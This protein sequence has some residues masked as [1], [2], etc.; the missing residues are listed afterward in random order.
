MRMEL[1]T[2][3]EKTPKFWS[4]MGPQFASRAIRR[5]MP[6]LADG[7]GHVWFVLSDRRDPDNVQAFMAAHIDDE[8][9]GRLHE[10]YAASDADTLAPLVIEAAI[11]WLVRS[12]VKE[13]RA[14][15]SGKSAKWLTALGFETTDSK[16]GYQR[17]RKV[18]AS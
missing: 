11:Q 18:I 14:S 7:P 13:M 1:K 9:I 10:P 3:E 6:Y 15:W 8:G 12:G 2:Y 4:V 16:G 5:A 17:M